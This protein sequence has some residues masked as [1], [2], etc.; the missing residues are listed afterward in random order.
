MNWNQLQYII[1]VAEEKNITRAAEKLYISQPSL[2]LSI[3]SLERELNTTLFERKNGALS[4]TYAGLLFYDWAVSTLNSRKQLSVKL[5]DISNELRHL[6]RIGISPHRSPILLPPI[7]EKFFSLYPQSEVSIVE[8]PTYTLKKLLAKEQVDFIIDIAHIDTVNY[9]SHL[10][11]EEKLVLAVPTS[12]LKKFPEKCENDHPISLE[13][14]ADF[15]F[16]V[17]SPEHFIG[18]MTKK[19]FDSVEFHPNIR[20]TCHAIETAIFCVKQQ[21]GISIVPEIY[22]K[23]NYGD[24]KI[25]YFEI[26]NIHGTRQ[27][28]LVHHKKLYLHHQLEALIKLFEEMTSKLYAQNKIKN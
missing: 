11:V 9:E 23:Q 8:E 13:I 6:I 2:S 12:Y 26:D 18:D 5:N 20:I 16:L 4:L 15:P 1:T 22:K 25:T 28:C 24:Q 17:L 7:L 27:I 10:L 14:L 19:I 21:L 3:H